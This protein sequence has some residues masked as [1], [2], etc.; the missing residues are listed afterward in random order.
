MVTTW[1]HAQL[2][3]QKFIKIRITLV[4]HLEEWRSVQTQA[5]VPLQDSVTPV[6]IAL[7]L[8]VD[9]NWP[10]GGVVDPVKL[11]QDTLLCLQVKSLK[12]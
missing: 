9:E 3:I 12:I 10:E 7:D 8:V 5:P 6:E 1:E 11:D 4:S 2:E